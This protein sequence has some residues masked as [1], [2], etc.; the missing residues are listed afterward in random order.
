MS[1]CFSSQAEYEDH[2]F[3]GGSFCNDCGEV[4]K[5]GVREL[6]ERLKAAEAKVAAALEVAEWI[7]GNH[8]D[9]ISREI[10]DRLRDALERP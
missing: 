7:R 5:P 1:N 10:E 9:Y 8:G 2:D 6:A 4:D 3:S